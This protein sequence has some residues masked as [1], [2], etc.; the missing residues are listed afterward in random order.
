MLFF[1]MK[2]ILSTL[3]I[4]TLT[5]PAM[6][7]VVVKGDL[8]YTMTGDLKPIENG[9]VVCDA[10]GKIT[11][12]GKQGAVELPANAKVLEAAVVTPGI[13]DCRT[14]VGLS[15]ILNLPRHDQEQADHGAPVQPELRAFDAYNGRD[16]LVSWLRNLGVTTVHT[17]HAPGA[18]VAGQTMVLKTNVEDIVNDGDTLR[19]LS[20]V[21]TTLGSTK[22]SGSPGT[23]AKAIAML[24]SELL[25]AQ[26]HLKK[27]DEAEEGEEPDPDLK[28]D[29]LTAA[30]RGEVPLLI[31]AHRH[32]DISAAL[33][34]QQEFKFKLVLSGASEAYLLLDEIKAAGCPVIVH[35]TMA[36]PFGNQRN[37]TF[38]MAAL[39]QEAG[40]PF[41]FQ[42]GYETYVPKVRVVLFEAAMAA[43]YGLTTE[44]ALAGCTINAAKILGL[45]ARLGS[46]EQGKDADLAL[47]E[48][49][50]LETVTRC[51][52]VLIDG[53]IQSSEAH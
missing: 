40:I 45:D 12:V 41:A 51:T 26:E 38:K 31:E 35:P 47:F 21:A 2:K 42:S 19:P 16:P 44:E 33:R 30:L 32:H 27:V 7:Q 17:G 10:A 43:A 24:R 20:M 22:G 25:K 18:L 48:G 3:L 53:E 9:V 5:G 1:T 37:L 29:I 39:L 46:L 8:V 52:G 50:P 6:A 34:L 28:L 49:D 15:G 36:R 14:T 4:L 13:I 11:A 23:R